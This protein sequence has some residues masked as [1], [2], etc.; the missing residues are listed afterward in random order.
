MWTA[1]KVEERLSEAADVLARLPEERV[2]GYFNVWPEVVH[3]FADK[4]GQMPGP[5]RRPR[6]LPDAISRMEEA[7]TWLRFLAPEDGKL[8]WARAEGTPWKGICWRFGIARATAHRRWRYAI[9]VITWRLNGRRV[10]TKRSRAFL[11]SHRRSGI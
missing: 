5:M 7:L 8:V 6:P 1:E 4:V 9:S 3:G 10:P 2:Q 11:V